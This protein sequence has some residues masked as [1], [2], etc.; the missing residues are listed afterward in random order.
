MSRKLFR[1]I[2]FQVKNM[3][4]NHVVKVAAQLRGQDALRF[5]QLHNELGGSQAVTANDL[6]TLVLAHA[7]QRAVAMSKNSDPIGYQEEQR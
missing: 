1:D 6:A 3:G 5:E 7:L 4:S 2:S